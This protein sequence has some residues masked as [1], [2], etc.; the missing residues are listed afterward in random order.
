MENRQIVEN[1]LSCLGGRENVL[2]VTNCMTRLRVT[3]KKEER[4]DEKKLKTTEKV[5]GLVHDRNFSYEV[6]VGPGNS[7]RFADICHEM[8]YSAAS[9]ESYDWKDTKAAMKAGQKNSRIKVLLKIIGDIFVPLIPGIISAGLCAGFASLITQI[10]PEYEEKNI[11]YLIHTLLTVINVSFMTYITAWAGYRA[12][13]RFGATPILGG[14]L[15]MITSLSQIDS[16]SQVLGLYNADAPL[17]SVLRSGKGGVLAVICGVFVLSVVEKKIRRKMP[18]S[19]DIVL[20]PLL[21]L[22]ICCVPYILVIMPA[23]GYVSNAIVWVFSKACMSE[24]AIVRMIVGYAASA[25][26]LPLVASG[27]HHGL[28]ALYTVQLQELGFITLYPALAMAGAGQVGAAIA[29]HRK[30][31]KINHRQ[32]CSVING[33]LPAGFLGVGE[34]LIYGVTLPMGRPF[35]TAGIGAGF[36]GA[37]VMLFQVASTTWGPSGLLGI[38][39]MTAGPNGTVSS[40]LMY[41]IG[42]ILSY[43]MSF[44]ITNA[45]ITEKEIAGAL[46]GIPLPAEEAS[47]SDSMDLVEENRNHLYKTIRHGEPVPFEFGRMR[48][49]EYIIKDPAGIHARPAGELSKLVAETGCEV[50][51]RNGEKSASGKSILEL[52]MLG[53]CQG[54]RLEVSIRGTNAEKAAELLQQFMVEML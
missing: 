24:S 23:L 29:L 17:Q 30:A 50:T 45:V 47:S 54:S 15:G 40:M 32:L 38:F 14:M 5:L 41:L 49:F 11:W 42:L 7:R 9:V 12:A 53:A 20:T 35:I 25:L 48:T 27:M 2:S 19:I 4:V 22:L 36:G 34:P 39:V 28:V 33:S 1:I 26:F 13:E 21:T 51:V 3:V 18:A 44:V 6:V 8:G 46:G 10:V 16:I 43:I 31:R 52:M 37:F